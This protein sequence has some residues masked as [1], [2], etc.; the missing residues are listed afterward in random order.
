MA[1]IDESSILEGITKADRIDFTMLEESAFQ[2]E[3]DYH[4]LGKIFQN[5]SSNKV[6]D[7]I[8]YSRLAQRLEYLSSDEE[9]YDSEVREDMEN[10]SEILDE[11]SE[12]EFEFFKDVFSLAMELGLACDMDYTNIPEASSRKF[13]SFQE[14]IDFVQTRELQ[15]LYKFYTLFKVLKNN[16]VLTELSEE[17]QLDYLN[18]VK[19]I[20]LKEIEHFEDLAEYSD[21]GQN[22]ETQDLIKKIQTDTEGDL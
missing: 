12:E 11:H 17:A 4:L 2:S 5:L 20:V 21:V 8:L 15:S 9:G 22:R 10:V 14:M 6:A 13:Q 7:A 16:S 1:F 18:I 19:S 3:E